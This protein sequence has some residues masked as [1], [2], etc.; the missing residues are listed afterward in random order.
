MA[1]I[2]CSECGK[3]ISDKAEFCP[4]CGN[5]TNPR[6]KT[7][8]RLGGVY[9]AA[10]FVIILLGMASMFTGYGYSGILFGTGF[11]VF[12]VGRLK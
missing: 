11:A 4:G 6:T 3:K 2:Q 1:L 12:I 8:K 10:G 9:E 5:P 7:V